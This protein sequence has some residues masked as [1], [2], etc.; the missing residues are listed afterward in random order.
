MCA[1]V[2]VEV[3]RVAERRL[4]EADENADAPTL[5]PAGVGFAAETGNVARAQGL[6]A[7]A[8]SPYE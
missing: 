3:Q 6:I 1:T 5:F 2:G 4:T 8:G 7:D